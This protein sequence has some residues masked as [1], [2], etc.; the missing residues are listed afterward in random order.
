MR[1]LLLA[2]G[3]ICAAAGVTSWVTAQNATTQTATMPG[4][5]IVS[6]TANLSHVGQ[7]VGQQVGHPVGNPINIPQD[8]PLMRRYDPTRPYD[9]FKGTNIDPKAVVTP[10]PGGSDSNIF[11]RTYDRVKSVLGMTKTVAPTGMV[12]PGIFRR[13]R[14]RAEARMWRWD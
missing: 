4:G 5:Q 11:A 13:N 2:A 3:V 1:Q 9:V 10:M 7:Q 14:E 12:T 6:T 8:N